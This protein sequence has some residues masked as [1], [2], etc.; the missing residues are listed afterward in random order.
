MPALRGGIPNQGRI[1][2]AYLLFDTLKDVVDEK[3]KT[4]AQENA[5]S[6]IRV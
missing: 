1:G 2:E 3:P 5:D 4:I 6:Q